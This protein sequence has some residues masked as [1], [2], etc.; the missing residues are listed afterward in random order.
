M[1][2]TKELKEKLLNAN[3]EEEVKALLGDQATEAECSRAWR[4]IQKAAMEAVDD[5]ELASV[6]GGFYDIFIDKAPD[7][8]DSD[9][10]FCFHSKH[11]CARSEHPDGFHHFEITYTSAQKILK[12]KYCGYTDIY[13][14]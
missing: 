4:E 8:F 1:E 12:C 10:W 13:D 7:G 9:C 3:S 6:S 14:V 2:I 5:D 11:E